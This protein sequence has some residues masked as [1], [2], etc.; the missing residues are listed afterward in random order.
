MILLIINGRPR[1]AKS[2]SLGF[3]IVS[4]PNGVAES[5]P[6]KL[7]EDTVK[8]GA[9]R[10]NIVSAVE[11]FSVAGVPDGTLR[12]DVRADNVVA[13]LVVAGSAVGVAAANDEPGDVAGLEADLKRRDANEN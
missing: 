2:F 7:T 6:T 11:A 3:M 5:L 10:H 13:S 1:S 4:R 8:L 9:T 12:S